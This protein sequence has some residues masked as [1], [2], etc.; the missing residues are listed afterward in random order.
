[1]VN[2]EL[3]FTQETMPTHMRYLIRSVDALHKRL[4]SDFV[5]QIEFRPI[6]KMMNYGIYF[7]IGSVLSAL[8]A[9]V[10]LKPWAM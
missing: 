6:K 7:L 8:L 10:V 5:T 1:M 9:I 3:E 2:G 4:D